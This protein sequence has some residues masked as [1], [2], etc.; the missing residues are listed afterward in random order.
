MLTCQAGRWWQTGVNCEHG[1]AAGKRRQ[2]C[3]DN[4]MQTVVRIQMFACVDVSWL[5]RATYIW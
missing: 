4:N 1:V 5:V 3:A 2:M